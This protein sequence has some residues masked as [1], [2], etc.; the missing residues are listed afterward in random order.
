MRGQ[1]KPFKTVEE[2]IEILKRRGIVF[3]NERHAAAF[4]LREN[5][6]A[7]VNGY[8]DAFLDKQ[9][10]NLAGE[11]KYP[12]GLPF[13]ALMFAYLFDRVLRRL[14]I[15]VLLEAE[16]NV[17]TAIAYS[18][19][20]IHAGSEDYLDPSC[21]CKRDEYGR[22]DRYTK[23]II[24]LLS[25]LQSI[26]DNKQHK[27]YIKHYID[28][29]RHL[30]L[31]VASKCMT[32]GNLSSF[33][34]LQQQ[35]VKTKTCV[36]LARSLGKDVVRQRELAYSLHTLPEFRNICAHDER[37]YC[38]KVGKNSDK[39]FPELLR[40][41]KTV[42]TDQSYQRYLG[43]VADMVDGLEEAVPSLKTTFLDGMGI[44]ME[45]LAAQGE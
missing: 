43:E 4:L 37:L 5:Y 33:F 26:R 22:P 34:D 3:S 41:L 2:Q 38:A 6:Y 18:F 31:W 9:A 29:H 17:K 40:A 42:V 7:V 19:C 10:S 12:Q 20:E 27:P 35:R 15:S 30:P 8:K 16:T 21:Y 1:S 45:D 39:G 44:S 24:R 23:D 14:T 11:D 13:E 28:C 25:T 32:F 36:V